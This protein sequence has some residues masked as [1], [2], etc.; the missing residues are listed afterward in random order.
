M[1]VFSEW[2][3]ETGCNP[4]ASRFVGSNP[5]APIFANAKSPQGVDLKT[6]FDNGELDPCQGEKPGPMGMSH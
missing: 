5:T 6:T 1:G 3:K 4:V 2:S